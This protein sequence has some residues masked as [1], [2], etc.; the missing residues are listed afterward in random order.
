MV[1]HVA[2]FTAAEH[3]TSDVGCAIDSDFGGVHVGQ[4]GVI[5]ASHAS[6]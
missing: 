6:A 2:V 3:G 1:F 4:G 5:A